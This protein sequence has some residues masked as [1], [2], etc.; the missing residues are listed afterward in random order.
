VTDAYPLFSWGQQQQ[1]GRPVAPAVQPPCSAVAADLPQW[2]RIVQVLAGHR[3]R[4]QAITAPAIA[5]A[6]GLWPGL[7]DANRGTRVREVIA[8]CQDHWPW[9]I[10]GDA[11]GYYL[12]ATAA[13]LTAYCANL[14]SRAV[15]ILRRFGSVR[16]S[17]RRAGYCYHGHGRFSGSPPGPLP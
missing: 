12:A 7:S 16:R 6:A 11:E 10:C 5:V 17:G 13:E 3:G 8:Q 1:T 2:G 15:Q 4:E 9:P 14:R